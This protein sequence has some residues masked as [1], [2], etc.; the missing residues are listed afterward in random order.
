MTTTDVSADAALAA[1]EARPPVVAED[2]GAPER[3][4]AIRV[5]DFR[6]PKTLDRTRIRGLQVLYEALAHRA[7]GLLTNRLRTPV[8]LTLGEFEQHTWGDYAGTL[9]E[10]TCLFAATMPPL[11]GRVV[12]HVPLDLAMT[13]V[14]LRMGGS[15]RGRL[16][17]LRALTE[18]EQR[19]VADVADAV[20]SELPSVL[21]QVMPLQLGSPMQ[22]SSAQFLPPVRP[23]DMGLLV[24]LVFEL[25]ET[26][27]FSFELCFPFSIVQPLVETL[28][29][30]S[31]EEEMPG[32]GDAE[33]IALRLLETSVDIRV[34]FPSTTLTPADFLHLAV[35]DVVGLP[36]DQGDAL[37]LTVGE[38]HHLDVLPTNSG[39]RLACVVVDHVE[40]HS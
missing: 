12:L 20:L 8:T 17:D 30:Q 40:K 39:K 34:R 25:S 19:L 9:A 15:G 6:L 24:P 28:A 18:I 2:G 4:A 21:A 32:I 35:G 16:P 14:D 37:S 36:Y 27:R 33:A 5:H 22:V 7:S 26:A 38:Q 1:E 23:T 10:P 3:R 31:Q 29:A 13:V 11:Q